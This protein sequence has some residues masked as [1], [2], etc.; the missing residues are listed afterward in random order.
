MLN[1][2]HTSGMLFAKQIVCNL[3]IAILDFSAPSTNVN[4]F[5]L[6]QLELT[7]RSPCVRGWRL[8][9]LRKAWYG[10]GSVIVICYLTQF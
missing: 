9:N 1:Q 7:L 3:S 5:N 2:L 8:D 4:R 10:K 6:N